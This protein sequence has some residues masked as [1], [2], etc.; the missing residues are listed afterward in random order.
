[1]VIW[2]FKLHTRH[3]SL[4]VYFQLKFCKSA[5]RVCGRNIIR[6]FLIGVSLVFIKTVPNVGPTYAYELVVVQQTNGHNK[7]CLMRIKTN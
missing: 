3:L 6:Q 5:L 7:F 1:M 2:T 4:Y